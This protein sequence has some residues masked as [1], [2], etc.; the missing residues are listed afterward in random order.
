MF[1]RTAAGIRFADCFFSEP[2]PF[3]RLA[4][5]ISSTGVYVILV[6]DPTWGPRQFQPVFFGEFGVSHDSSIEAMELM[7]CHRVAAGRGLYVAVCTAFR[8]QSQDLARLKRDLIL[9]YR[10]ICNRESTV[11]GTPGMAQRVEALEKKSQEQETLL[12]LALTALGQFY[13]TPAESRK[14]PVG[15]LSWA[16]NYERGTA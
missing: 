4:L 11:S 7:A 5:P 9:S 6:P 16:G 1:A 10:P 14:R 2:V 13:Q 8:D 15:F 3:G 12:K